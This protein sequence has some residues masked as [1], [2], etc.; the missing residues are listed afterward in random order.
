MISLILPVAKC[1]RA[2]GGDSGDCSFQLC[3]MGPWL[4]GE[5]KSPH[6]QWRRLNNN[7]LSTELP[8]RLPWQAGPVH[9]R[10]GGLPQGRLPPQHQESRL[11]KVSQLHC[12]HLNH[13]DVQ[14]NKNLLRSTPCSLLLPTS[15]SPT[16]LNRFSFHHKHHHLHFQC[17]CHHYFIF[18]LHFSS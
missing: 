15:S 12:Y 17:N 7:S 1:R 14:S 2:A 3:Q 6:N 16:I 18:G 8:G 10:W 9:Q 5:I 13:S 11:G 4:S